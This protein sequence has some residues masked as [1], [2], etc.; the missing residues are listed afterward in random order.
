[1]KPNPPDN[2]YAAY[3]EVYRHTP[4]VRIT[5][6]YKAPFYRDPA[7]PWLIEWDDQRVN[8][9]QIGHAANP[10]WRYHPAVASVDADG[11]VT[12]DWSRA[13][14]GQPVIP[15]PPRLHP[16]QQRAQWDPGHIAPPTRPRES[17][18]ARFWNRLAGPR[19]NRDRFTGS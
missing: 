2:Y 10:Q 13:V 7:K 14:R 9:P 18:W 16:T 6:T 17:L 1:M 3:P 4:G 19:D 5:Y 12:W 8:V 11:V 15:F